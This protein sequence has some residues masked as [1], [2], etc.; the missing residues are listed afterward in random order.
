MI[1][2][3]PRRAAP[4]ALRLGAHRSAPISAALA[5]A[6]DAARLRRRAARGAPSA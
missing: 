4:L 5:L 2:F 6:A 1:R 3:E